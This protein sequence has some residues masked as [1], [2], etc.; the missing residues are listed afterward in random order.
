MSIARI[1]QQAAGAGG[2]LDIADAF[3]TD[4]Y[5]GNGSTQT[6]TNG[7]DL[8]GEGG[9]VWI[10]SRS[11]AT[12]H[13]LYDT[14][15]GSTSY[16]VSSGTGAEQTTTSWQISSF[17]S[18]GFGLSGSNNVINGSGQTYAAWTFR[19][20][21]RFFDVVTYTGDGVAGRSIPH[22]LGVV[23]GMIVVKRRDLSGPSWPVYHRAN[24]AAPE[25]DYLLLESTVATADS[26][27]F[28]ND[29]APTD[30]VFTVRNKSDVNA[31]GGT[32]VA[33]L[34]AHDTEADGVIQCGSYT[35]NG[36]TSGPTINLG[37]EPQWVMIKQ[38]SSSG[39]SW[40]IFDKER[41]MTTGNDPLIYAN[42]SNSEITG[43]DFVE[44]SST[45]FQV[46]NTSPA[47]NGSG[48]TYI[49]IAIRAEGA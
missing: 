11:V 38:S 24:T 40:A 46:K 5:T 12:A 8:A 23:P 3:S 19:Q 48:E 29:T 7:I 34:F 28:W 47:V 1:L 10:K 41:G 42:S 45:G 39:T 4:L 26:I 44:A 32:Y 33:Y 49:Y 43:L 31:S 6:I 9:L 16:L 30:T 35:G 2:A 20:A 37:W 17:N 18:D 25:T 13:L 22:N 14:L 15:R 36:S 27:D 21:P